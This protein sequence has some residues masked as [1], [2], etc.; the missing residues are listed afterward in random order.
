MPF[1]TAKALFLAASMLVATASHAGD[2]PWEEI[3]TEAEV[4]VSRAEVDG[5]KLF[6]FKGETIMDASRGQVLHVLLD[7]EHRV[8]WVDRLYTN[9]IVERKTTFDYVLYQAFDLP[10]MFAS[11]DYV[12]HGVVTEDPTSGVVTLTMQSVEHPDAPETVGVRAE[13]LNSRYLLTPVEDGN[14]TRVEVEIIT[15]P[16]GM[17]PS[18]L[19]N[20]IQKSWPVDTLNALRG[21]LSKP[22]AGV[23]PLPLEGV[24]PNE[25]ERRIATDEGE[26]DTGDAGPTLADGVEPVTQ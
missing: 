12:Y 1:R 18:W 21:E 24:T 8:E 22:Y 26:L 17:M 10:A 5:T 9:S 3:Y 25:D 2:L 11:R 6:A 7:N 15:D 14:K 16:K 23:H 20:V 4:T 13:L 19:V